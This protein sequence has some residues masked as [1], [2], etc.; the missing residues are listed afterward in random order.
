[1]TLEVLGLFSFSGITKLFFG[2]ISN[3]IKSDTSIALDIFAQ[4]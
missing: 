3:F 4:L 2:K 1:M